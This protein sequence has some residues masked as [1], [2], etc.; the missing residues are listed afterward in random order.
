MPLFEVELDDGRKFQVDADRQPTPEEVASA[1]PKEPET[2][3]AP[4]PLTPSDYFS[5]RKADLQAS[6]EWDKMP[7]WQRTELEP[8]SL[9]ESLPRKL[10]RAASTIPG[11]AG[12][13]L[14]A[15][16]KALK[17]GAGR[18]AGIPGG[19]EDIG[20]SI[21]Q[22]TP[23]PVEQ[24]VE[25]GG[26]FIAKAGTGMLETLPKLGMLAAFPEGIVAQSLAAGGLFGLDERGGFS[27]KAA[28]IGALMPG[29]GK[30]AMGTAA[31]GL[32]KLGVESTLVQKA[33]EELAHQIGLNTLMMAG[34]SKELIDLYKEDPEKAKKRMA[35]TIGQ[36][37]AWSLFGLPRWRKG[38]PSETQ[39]FVFENADKYA[40]LANKILPDLITIPNLEQ[41]QARA[42]AEF[43]S[44]LAPKGRAPT[45]FGDVSGPA[46]TPRFP[47]TLPPDVEPTVPTQPAGAPPEVVP[48]TPPQF[49]GVPPVGTPVL[50]PR[51]RM[52][53]Q[54]GRR[55]LAAAPPEPTREEPLPSELEYGEGGAMPQYT[56][57]IGYAERVRRDQGQ[58]PAPGQ[59]PENREEVRGNDVQ[60]PTPGA[61]NAPAPAPPPPSIPNEQELRAGLSYRLGSF[62][63]ER[64]PQDYQS[65]AMPDVFGRNAPTW[66]QLEQA[67]IIKSKPLPNG[68]L[69]MD[70]VEPERPAEVEGEGRFT[71]EQIRGLRNDIY[72][73]VKNRILTDDE[74]SKL[75]TWGQET[76]RRDPNQD[77]LSDLNVLVS[78]LKRLAK[79]K[80]E[81]KLFKGMSL[82]DRFHFE[83][84]KLERGENDIMAWINETGAMLSKAAFRKKYGAERAKQNESLYEG[85]PDMSAA[86]WHNSAI[87]NKF[88]ST[89][90][91]VADNAIEAGIIKAR[92]GWQPVDLLWE[93]V[94][95]SHDARLALRTGAAKPAE[96]EVEEQELNFKEV[97][98]SEKGGPV[99]V[100]KGELSVG[101]KLVVQGEDCL[102][103]SSREDKDG[104]KIFRLEDGREFGVQYVEDDGRPMYVEQWIQPEGEEFGSSD[105]VEP[106]KEQAAPTPPAQPAAVVPE[107]KP[108]LVAAKGSQ[109]EQV[110]V[111]QPAP[112]PQPQ[113][114]PQPLPPPQPTPVEKPKPSL[115][116]TGKEGQELDGYK[117]KMWTQKGETTPVLRWFKIKEDGSLHPIPANAKQTERLNQAANLPP[118]AA[119]TRTPMEILNQ[120]KRVRIT[121]PEGATV[122]RATSKGGG[123]AEMFIADVNRGSNVFEGADIVKLEAGT[124]DKKG[125]FN[126]V[127]GEIKVTEAPRDASVEPEAKSGE[128]REP[129]ILPGKDITLSSKEDVLRAI[130][131]PKTNITRN[132]RKALRFLVNSGLLERLPGLKLQITDYIRG[133]ILGEYTG[134][135]ARF[136]RWTK[137]DVPIHEFMHHLHR[138]LSPED[139]QF[140]HEL[141]SQVLAKEAPQMGEDF[142]RGI[143]SDEFVKRGINRDL[144]HLA[145][146]NEFFAW[147]MTK[148]AQREMAVMRLFDPAKGFI[149]R[150]RKAVY[151]LYRTLRTALGFGKYEDALWNDIIQ[152]RYKYD[153]GDALKWSKSAALDERGALETLKEKLKDPDKRNSAEAA[154]DEYRRG[155]DEEG[156]HEANAFD[157]LR[158]AGFTKPERDI[159]TRAFYNK[160][161]RLNDITGNDREA[162]LLR[163][164]LFGIERPVLENAMGA[165]RAAVA[166]GQPPERAVEAGIAI[167]RENSPE[168]WDEPGLRTYLTAQ[169]RTE[170]SITPPPENLPPP[171]EGG[172]T[173]EGGPIERHQVLGRRRLGAEYNQQN[174]QETINRVRTGYFDG[175]Q[176]VEANRTQNA[177]EL[178]RQ[179]T[180]P[181]T[182]LNFLM[183]VNE[184]GDS[185]AGMDMGASALLN[186]LMD[187]STKLAMAGDSRMMNYIVNRYQDFATVFGSR[188]QAGR[189][190]RMAREGASRP[191]WRA[192]WS[193]TDYRL[194]VAGRS[195]GVGPAAMQELQ[196][197]IDMMRLS[198]Q[199]LEAAIRNP[200][201]VDDSGK[202]IE[203][204]L[205]EK[206]PGMTEAER[207]LDKYE[208]SQTEWLKPDGKLSPLRE[209]IKDALEKGPRFEYVNG[210]EWVNALSERF[211][212]LADDE[213]SALVPKDI[214]D[215]L[216]FE[217]WKDKQA[218]ESAA[219]AKARYAEERREATNAERFL[220]SW[221]KEQTEWVRPEKINLT[222]DILRE[223]FRRNVDRNNPQ[224]ARDGLTRDFMGAGV[225]ENTARE[226]AFQA[227]N[228]KMTLD[229]AAMARAWDREREK[230]RNLA[231]NTARGYM[232]RLEKKYGAE[233]VKPD[234]RN[235]VQDIIKE[236]LKLPKGGPEPEAGEVPIAQ[237][238]E[239]IRDLSDR[240][241]GAGVT[242]DTALRVARM[243]YDDRAT[244]WLNARNRAMSRASQSRNISSLIEA[245]NSSPYLAQKDPVWR[246]QTAEDWFMSNG[247]SRDQA[248]AAAKLFEKAYVDAFSKAAE[249]VAK[250]V[251]K[252]DD[253]RSIEEVVKAIRAGLTDPDK[254]WSEELAKR[255]GWKPLTPE[256]HQQLAALEQK[257]SAK[258]LLDHDRADIINQ[259]TNILAHTGDPKGHFAKF[260]GESFAASL[261]SG[262]RT[263]NLHIFQ[264]MV[265]MAAT[266]ATHF[267][268]EPRDIGVITSSLVD[269]AKAWFNEVKY[270]WPKD[271][272][273]FNAEQE[274]FYHN[275]LKRQFEIA[276]KEI[277]EGKWFEKGRGVLRII[278]AWQQ[279]TIRALQVANQAGMEAM[280]EQKMLLYG[281]RAMRLAGATTKEIGELVEI[282]HN[283]WSAGYSHF[284]DQGRS[285]TDAKALANDFA[286]E[287]LEN[288]FH[289]RLG[290]GESGRVMQAWENDV[291]SIVGR[292]APGITEA[293]ENA[294]GF[295]SQPM[296]KLM[297]FATR[298]RR[299][300]GWSSILM[301]SA[302]GFMNVPFRLTRYYAGWSP[303]GLIRYGLYRWRN[304]RNL[305]NLWPQSYSSD[306]AARQRLREAVAGTVLMATFLGWQYAHST[307]D[308]D[309]DKRAFAMYATG[310]GP[311]NRTLRDAWNKK[312]FHPF[313]LNVVMRGQVVASIPITRVGEV[314][315]YPL[316]LAA[317]LDDVAWKNKEEAAIGK[318]PKL[319][320]TRMLGSIAGS[321]Y[322][323]AGAQ[324]VFQ[325]FG[326]VSQ[327]RQGEGTMGRAIAT[328]AASTAS[329]ALVPGKGLM[330]SVTDLVYGPVDRSSIE[331][332]A[333]ANF[334]VL[335]A[336]YNGK[337]L[338]RFGDA[339]GDQTWFGRLSRTGIPIAFRFN[340]TAENE[341]LYTLLADKGTAPPD[342]RRYIIEERY[343]AL[344][345]E[346]WNKFAKR[347]G[348]ILKQNVMEN[349]DT[350]KQSDPQ[351]V[352]QF[353]DKAG[354][355]ANDQAGADLGLVRQVTP[356]RSS[357]AGL[358]GSGGG[359]ATSDR[360]TAPEVPR[361]E[362]PEGGVRVAGFTPRGG[363]VPS[364]RAPAGFGARRGGA[365]AL[366]P[367]LGATA[368]RRTGFRSS[369]TPR[370]LRPRLRGV[371]RGVRMHRPATH[372]V[373]KRRVRN[374]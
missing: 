172:A 366:R 73:L 71:Q 242:R 94:K 254:E 169:A 331:S 252:R 174:I 364:Y 209:L 33:T 93:A 337:N 287:A 193:M 249:K 183:T 165:V 120:A 55:V 306:L 298:N 16:G 58:L 201:V 187:Y 195:V 75:A 69:R 28:I 259:M 300:G 373:R 107:P 152:G 313:S 109:P 231:E 346:T 60:Q 114:A 105:F 103:T 133:G 51:T 92:Q 68:N 147:L 266:A 330:Q 84:S 303:Y 312:G 112:Q 205:E 199:D 219:T 126:P 208:R 196:R 82:M 192:L 135:F 5:Q 7:Y 357:Q 27:P 177:W 321:Y 317:A 119:E 315:A 243:V 154:I 275:E 354:Q 221:A 141:R 316:G 240:L 188:T 88:G 324:G 34:D 131:D 200:D 262:I 41:R 76:N 134:E 276:Q 66:Q 260:V 214:A 203:Q 369:V 295:L 307:A 38:V 15:A 197:T 162:S 48:G 168:A 97:T 22:G 360:V 349:L 320:T 138:F 212:A 215:R 80:E 191:L 77:V 173:E 220:D 248:Q 194:A 305:R 13:S 311:K 161:L 37:L 227:W 367:R 362:T 23:T 291:Y 301:I 285:P 222:R 178:I 113:A 144:Y 52:R 365:A 198:P 238:A 351:A 49:P 340:R 289:N 106:E 176:P 35:E 181:N 344:D 223:F 322:E 235:T 143:S 237:Q 347:S 230:E 318:N 50:L 245:I 283:F 179:M 53:V 8:E 368:S 180:D 137:A 211:Q 277:K 207:I 12:A 353:L 329:A 342:L 25:Q 36:N 350:L 128:T 14:G 202:T 132:T 155:I 18:L 57:R 241:I 100:D 335:N 171:I 108:E 363:G 299:E 166:A 4:K 314:L 217:V 116:A 47:V 159:I 46:P 156:D 309:A 281:S 129:V 104:N 359:A 334:P 125:N 145:N 279:Y 85:A 371:S 98:G 160:D 32:A 226:L 121:L 348:D 218:R 327:L 246:Q 239:F 150:V 61:P 325:S 86:P 269:A 244:R 124:K 140:I 358:G 115:A 65:P 261:L 110:A 24:D 268:T 90:D 319:P 304:Q 89:P 338:N 182:R 29:V 2:A 341:G 216:A 78:R 225:P 87:Y 189:D 343:G 286:N 253:P 21:F 157:T 130:D 70:Y 101:D 255:E 19:V 294:E 236:A 356:K 265:N 302:V 117:A 224:A 372:R 139:R 167:A 184:R 102:V 297:E 204:I 17:V 1:L 333:M 336:I 272:Y 247:L 6:G 256:Q 250:Q 251:L 190:L 111:A 339:L 56:E 271:A 64:R 20:K 10:M 308:D 361:I 79:P 170:S 30:V 163:G 148:K 326:H 164:R 81:P 232:E 263:I 153:V 257:L 284:I 278:F 63:V 42:K 258:N 9:T 149:T 62:G 59:V 83:T 45:E 345:Q 142:A 206:E 91:V 370:S 118:K 96:G 213:G 99:E 274:S 186:E 352:K 292:R 122:V 328:Q 332:A 39:K 95:R 355:Q 40:D 127:K 293:G 234:K 136:L 74:R 374:A 175:Q 31:R 67:G 185:E 233:W 11:A 310:D 151:D 282:K 296:N 290:S 229:D 3:P 267:V 264:P 280:R 273:S 146:D 72:Q 43:E 270:A 210:T 228:R 26:D 288:F 44:A 54:P 123:K 158:E 323:I